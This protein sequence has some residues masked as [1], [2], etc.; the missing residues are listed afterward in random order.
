LIPHNYLFGLKPAVENFGCVKSPRGFPGGSDGKES[1]CNAGDL[2]SIS[3]LGRYPGGGQGNPLQFSCLGNPHGQRSL[4]G[5]SPWV[6]KESDMTEQL[7][8]SLPGPCIS[9]TRINPGAFKHDL[10]RTVHS[11]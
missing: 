2:G 8:T 7:S 11:G 9:F 1:S 10:T 6:L 4:V 3:G 5:Y